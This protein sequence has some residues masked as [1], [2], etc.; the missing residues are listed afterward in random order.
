MV[1]PQQGEAWR[2]MLRRAPPTTDDLK[3]TLEGKADADEKRALSALAARGSTSAGIVEYL[4]L[5]RELIR[6]AFAVHRGERRVQVNLARILGAARF[7]CPR[8]YCYERDSFA[9]MLQ[10][11]QLV[12]SV[13][14]GADVAPFL[15]KM[16]RV[17]MVSEGTKRFPYMVEYYAARGGTTQG[18]GG[19]TGDGG[20]IWGE[21][22]V[23]DEELQMGGSSGGEQW[24]L[25][26][27]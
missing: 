24:S 13:V 27:I 11:Y 1:I 26:E 5:I 6:E 2:D 8:T 4:D 15:V 18:E 16:A 25:R 12:E 22:G 19:G 17:A 10:C 9:H 7:K 20:T 3:G 21:G 14:V 23:D